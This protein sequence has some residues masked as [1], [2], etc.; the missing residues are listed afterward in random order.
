M[1][2][3]KKLKDKITLPMVESE[4]I[5]LHSPQRSRADQVRTLIARLGLDEHDVTAAISWARKRK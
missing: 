1:L 2:A 3:K 4:C 5:A